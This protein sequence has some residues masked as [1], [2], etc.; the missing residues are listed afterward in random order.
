MSVHEFE[1]FHCMFLTKLVQSD[2]PITLRMFETK[3]SEEWSIYKLNDAVD[4]I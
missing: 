4:W 1:L 3:P 2:R